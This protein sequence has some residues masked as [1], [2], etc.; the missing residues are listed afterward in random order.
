MKKCLFC[1]LDINDDTNIC[2]YCHGNQSLN[3]VS[4][5]N[6]LSD[7][8]N[9]VPNTTIDI[10][11]NSIGTP[12]DYPFGIS[13]PGY[14]EQ[15]SNITYDELLSYNHESDSMLL[16]AYN[17]A[18]QNHPTTPTKL[19]SEEILSSLNTST[20]DMQNEYNTSYFNKLVDVALMDKKTYNKVYVPKYTYKEKKHKEKKDKYDI[21]YDGFYDNIEPVVLPS[22]KIKSSSA[23]NNPWKIL[24]FILIFVVLIF[25]IMGFGAISILQNF[26]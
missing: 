25:I 16:N 8:S 18:E 17:E 19:S 21:N 5:L 7:I 15:I 3:S 20:T 26:L 14:T 24:I 11:K 2:P 4:Q 10:S 6:P 9:T 23:K 12:M 1:Y 22:N 13:E